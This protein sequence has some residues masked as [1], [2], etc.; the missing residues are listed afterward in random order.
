MIKRIRSLSCTI[1]LLAGILLFFAVPNASF[2]ASN[3]LPLSQYSGAPGD[4]VEISYTFGNVTSGLAI[5]TFNGT[6]LGSATITITLS[7]TFQVLVLP[8]GTYTVSYR[9]R[10]RCKLF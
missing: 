5:I 6:Y 1:T 10:K 3:D 9:R 8:R 7:Y 2:S 4:T